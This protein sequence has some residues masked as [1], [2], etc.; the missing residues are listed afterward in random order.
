M[1]PPAASFLSPAASFPPPGEVKRL[2]CRDRDTM[3]WNP[4]SSAGTY[5]VYRDVIHAPG[6]PWAGSCVASGISGT[7]FKDATIPDPGTVWLHLV[8]VR[9]QLGELGTAGQNGAGQEQTPSAPCP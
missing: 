1:A 4:E 3:M 5:D 9:N 2:V 7:N 8:A 6:L